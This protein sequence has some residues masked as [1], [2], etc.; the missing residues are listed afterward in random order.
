[1]SAICIGKKLWYASV[2]ETT[3]IKVEVKACDSKCCT[4]VALDSGDKE[5]WLF[6]KEI[7]QQL[8]EDYEES[9]AGLVNLKLVKLFPSYLQLV[10]DKME[11]CEDSKGRFIEKIKELKLWEDKEMLE[12]VFE[13]ATALVGIDLKYIVEKSKNEEEQT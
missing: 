5:I 12:K 6:G 11:R 9:R 10:A 13:E 4:I 3:P 2:T 8:F 7:K 1:M